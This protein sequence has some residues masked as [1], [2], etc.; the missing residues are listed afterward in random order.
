MISAVDANKIATKTLKEKSEQELA[1]INTLIG[2]AA[3]SGNYQVVYNG[4]LSDGTVHV[5][6]NL[7]YKI[8]IYEDHQMLYFTI[9]LSQS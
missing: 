5:L 4:M 7:G 9:R 3:Q 8:D 1:K 2:N 6:K